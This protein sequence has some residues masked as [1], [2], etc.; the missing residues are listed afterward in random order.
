MQRTTA[1]AIGPAVGAGTG[2]R[3]RSLWGPQTRR[4]I[5]VAAVVLF[6]FL[7]G[8]SGLIYQVAW[9]RILSLIFGVT[10]HAVSTVLAGFMAGLALGSFLAGRVAGRLRYPLR[11]YGVLECLI[12]LAGVLTP[13]A[14]AW[15]RDAYPA[16]N[17]SAE[18]LAAGLA[19]HAAL[20]GL[21][22]WLPGVVRFLLAFG[23]LLVPTTLMGATLPVMLR[24]SLVQGQSLGRSVSLLYAINTFGAIAGTLAA[25]AA[26]RSIAR[27]SSTAAT[28]METLIA[29]AVITLARMP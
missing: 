23:I 20:G 21:A 9:V 7:S 5:F 10:V 22:F 27:E 8:A 15:L 28:P 18:S 2:G 11:A 24:S 6:F 29:A 4:L 3:A 25:G 19:G 12:G 16:V 14:F 1:T 26:G 13:W 17:A